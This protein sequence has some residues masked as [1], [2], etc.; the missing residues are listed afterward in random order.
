MAHMAAPTKYAEGP[1]R[2]FT[3]PRP[4][5]VV[6][7]PLSIL[8]ATCARFSDTSAVWLFE[9]PSSGKVDDAFVAKLKTSFIET[10]NA[11]PQ[12]AGQLH[13]APFREGGHHTERFNRS[14]VTY[15]SEADPGVEWTVVRHDYE[16]TSFALKTAESFSSEGLWDAG[17]AFPQRDL[18][19]PTRLALYNLRDFQGIPAMSVQISLFSCGGY[20]VG[21]RLAHQLGDAQSMMVFMHKWAANSRTIFTGGQPSQSLFDEPVFDPQQLDSR[22]AGDIDGEAADET[23]A[24]TARTLPL[25][26]FSWWDTDEPGYSPWLVASSKN[27][28]PPAEVLAKTN[29]SPSTLAPWKT[30]DLARPVSWGLVHFTGDELLGLQ[31]AAREGI[32]ESAVLSRTDALMAYLFR[33]ITRARSRVHVGDR[34]EPVYLNVSIDCRRR[35]ARP[36]PETFLG[37]PLLMTHIGAAS[38]AVC[39]ATLGDLALRLRNTLTAFTPD[40]LAAVLHDA[41][42]EVSPQRLWLGFMGSRHLIATSW[43]RLRAYDVDFEGGGKGP[44]YVHPVMEKCDGIVVVAD[45]LVRNGGVDASLYLDAEAWVHFKEEL[46]RKSESIAG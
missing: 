34:D 20:G 24:E 37:S 31:R 3:S 28:I 22:A 39:E 30:W 14:M 40:G 1:I 46:S 25:H 19:S 11:F 7:T 8:D 38:P 44:A 45:S 16:I 18:V 2:L 10:L 13:W 23:I 43:Q 41:A 29:V 33:T 5:T 42:H 32:P 27:S 36:L 35:V 17:D 6:K 21:V 9:A 4:S 15:G 26:R 12:W